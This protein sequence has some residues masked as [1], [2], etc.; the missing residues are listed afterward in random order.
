M[1]STLKQS[2]NDRDEILH[3]LTDILE[4]MFEVDPT[5]VAPDAL[6]YDD[7]DIDSIDA[8]DLIA[9]L[10]TLTGKKIEPDEFKAVRTVA[11]VVDAVY[12]LI[13]G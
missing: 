3:V 12:R 2:M 9:R 10:R 8:I 13:A 5:D 4:E 11:D 1:A 6:L 7:L